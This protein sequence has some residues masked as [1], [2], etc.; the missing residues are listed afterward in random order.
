MMENGLK[1]ILGQY[2]S[3]HSEIDQN[4]KRVT[5]R[6]SESVHLVASEPSV[7]MFRISEHVRR[8]V[9]QLVERKNSILDVYKH[10]T[11]CYFDLEYGNGA[12]QQIR[13]A[14]PHMDRIQELIKSATFLKQQILHV[15]TGEPRS[16]LH[17]SSSQSD[18]LHH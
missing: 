15:R 10:A 2:Q 18:H 16:Q 8:N 5:E 14:G 11:G 7:A 3:D 4:V 12:I 9:P 6:F 17:S 1:Y 13:N